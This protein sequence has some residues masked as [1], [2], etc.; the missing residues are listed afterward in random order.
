MFVPYEWPINEQ[1]KVYSFYLVV[2]GER[3][4]EIQV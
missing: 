2:M 4:K 3:G 1:I